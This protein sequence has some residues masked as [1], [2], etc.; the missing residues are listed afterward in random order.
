MRVSVD[1]VSIPATDVTVSRIGFGTASIHH[2]ATA[3]RRRTLLKQAFDSGITH[4]DTAP[5]YGYGVAEAALGDCF[6]SNRESITI[7][8]KFGLHP[9]GWA[10]GNVGGWARKL[11]GRL[12]PRL[13]QPVQDWTVERARASLRASLRRLKT[14]FVDFLFVHEPQI[15]ADHANR[16]QDWLSAEREAGRIRYFG[17]AG[18]YGSIGPLVESGHPISQVVQTEDSIN[19][20]GAGWLRR[21]GRPLQFT[22]GYLRQNA[23]Q[24]HDSGE[25]IRAALNLN[26]SGGVLVSTRRKDRLLSIVDYVNVNC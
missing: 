21:M 23:Q 3:G 10:P 22:Y 2:L 26:K 16:L 15:T 20:P 5:L 7:A 18:G 8:T 14:D 17:V 13:S 9:P 4:F 25:V 19:L 6:K 24:S 11:I 12:F 1:R